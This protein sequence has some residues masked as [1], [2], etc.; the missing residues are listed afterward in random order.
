MQI[1]IKTVII[2]L[3]RAHEADLA[4]SWSTPAP[5]TVCGRCET[6]AG[7]AGWH[8]GTPTSGETLIV[9]RVITAGAGRSPRAAK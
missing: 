8:A 4:G 9:A 7:E 2:C 6:L 3:D 1:C 5:R